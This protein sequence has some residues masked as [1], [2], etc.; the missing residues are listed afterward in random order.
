ME[1][2]TNKFLFPKAK[3]SYIFWMGQ[4]TTENG[5]M[6]SCTD[7][8][9]TAGK[10]VL[11]MKAAMLTVRKKEMECFTTLQVSSI[12]VCGPTGNNKVK[13]KS[14]QK[15]IRSKNKE[16]GRMELSK[17]SYKP[18]NLRNN[19]IDSNE[20]IYIILTFIELLDLTE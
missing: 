20:R 15:T 6:D 16:F 17:R 7:T 11:V 2:F 14:L 18:N 9:F 8:E 1:K 3:E 12:S 5:K 13:E 10:M 4:A 19:K